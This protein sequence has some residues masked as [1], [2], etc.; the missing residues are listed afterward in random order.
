M[1][2]T[3]LNAPSTA[4]STIMTGSATH[5]LVP[6]RI[7]TAPATRVI[8]YEP[9]T[10]RSTSRMARAKT[11]PSAIRLTYTEFCAVVSRL[12]VLRKSG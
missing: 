7:S 3:P 12:S 5:G 9:P 10:D 6:P 1:A 4:P 11:M 8:A 2:I